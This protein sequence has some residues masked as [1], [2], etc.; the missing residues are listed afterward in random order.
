MSHYTYTLAGDSAPPVGLIVLQSDE[1]IEGDFRRMLPETVPLYVSRVPSD[2]EVTPETLQRMAGHLTGAASLFP[3]PLKFTTVGYGCTSG[4]AQIG[5]DEIAKLV[6]AGTQAARVTNPLTALVNACNALDVTSV[7][8]LSPYVADV[9]D[10]LR[11]ALADQGI[12]SPTFGSFNEANE[13]NVVRISAASIIDAAKDLANQGKAQA[14][15]L[16]CTNLRTMDVIEKIEAATGLPCLSSNQVLA[17]DMTRE[18]G[19]QTQI[20][21]RLGQL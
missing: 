9:S 7:A 20:P 15:F 14:I 5:A 18:T 16:S 1:T 8:F 4:T 12:A 2:E 13:A 17:W 6:C 10:R 21:G 3:T 11:T 19:A